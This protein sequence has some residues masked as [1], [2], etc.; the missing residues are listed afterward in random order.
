MSKYPK[1]P[2]HEVELLIPPESKPNVD[3]Y[4]SL[5]VDFSE[6]GA[7]YN[8][9]VYSSQLFSYLYFSS[10]P[11]KTKNAL[12]ELFDRIVELE[13]SPCT[14][15]NDLNESPFFTPDMLTIDQSDMGAIDGGYFGLV[16]NELTPVDTLLRR[17]AVSVFLEANG[18]LPYSFLDYSPDAQRRLLVPSGFWGGGCSVVPQCESPVVMAKLSEIASPSDLPSLVSANGMPGIWDANPIHNLYY[19]LDLLKYVVEKYGPV[20]GPA[21]VLNALPEY[22][23][24]R[25][26]LRH[27]L[28]APKYLKE[29]GEPVKDEY[30]ASIVL[31]PTGEFLPCTNYKMEVTVHLG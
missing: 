21:E 19:A 28:Y 1:Y 16:N 17:Q 13:N 15:W 5:Y 26:K 4:A 30:G 12:G 7:K 11:A 14:G 6:L 23:S 10:G 22:M 31:F 20:F 2:K 9:V 18:I 25:L 8:D 29:D 3:N 27:Q 24:R